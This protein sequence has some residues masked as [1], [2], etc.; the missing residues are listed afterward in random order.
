VARTYAPEV[1]IP[2]EYAWMSIGFF[3]PA[4]KAVRPD[5]KEGDHRQSVLYSLHG[6]LARL[7]EMKPDMLPTGK[8]DLRDWLNL[9]AEWAEAIY[10]ANSLPQA[11]Y[12]QIQ[13][14][15]FAARQVLDAHF[16]AF[17][18]NRY[19]AAHHYQDNRGPI[20][21]PAVNGWLQMQVK[22]EERLALVCFDGLA[23]DQW[24]L[25]RNYLEQMLPGLK[26]LE[27]RT[28]AVAPTLTPI[29]RQA[30]FAGRSPSVF[31]D[32]I[33]QTTK[34]GDRWQAFWVN[35]DIP[36]LRVKYLAVQVNGA[37]MDEVPAIVDSKN[38][39]LGVLVNV[40]DDVMH[41][42]KGMTPETDKRVYYAALQSHLE[43]G[44]LVELFQ[45]LFKGHYRVFITADHGNI[46]GVGTGITPPKA[47]VES[48][49]RRVALFVD[50]QLGDSYV[51]QHEGL[52]TF[53]TKLLPTHL[54]PVYLEGNQLF[55]SKGETSIS[56][57]GLSIEELIVPFVEVQSV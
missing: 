45:S 50:L 57:G 11:D 17:L 55:A 8:N 20:S 30:L 12:E 36:A 40:F 6:R 25:L 19:G 26:F 35:H 52:Y 9:A 56:H 29:S 13:P 4:G 47:L 51:Q 44:R 53:R 31:E 10:Q 15:L 41:S 27:N 14:V 23:L 48:Y 42:I 22:P 33:L 16:W 28:Y 2:P 32:T 5:V 3:P 46:A 54:Y 43:N 7:V 39:R 24:Y 1:A 21:L 49:A 34:D 18:Q 37:G 38:R